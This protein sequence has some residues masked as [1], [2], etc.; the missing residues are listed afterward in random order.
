MVNG[1]AVKHRNNMISS[2]PLRK[3]E[4]NIQNQ[5]FQFQIQNQV[6]RK[7][8]PLKQIRSTEYQKLKHI[9]SNSNTKI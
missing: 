4:L 9:Q 1:M 8:R 7:I 2:Q 5:Y 3:P 6:T